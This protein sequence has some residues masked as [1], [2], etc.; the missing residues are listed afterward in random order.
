MLDWLTIKEVHEKTKIAEGTIRRYLNLHHR[1]IKNTK[2]TRNTI[3][4][5]PAS[6]PT[7]LKIR[8]WYGEGLAREQVEEELAATEPMSIVVS[9][10]EKSY[11]LGE[12]IGG[13]NKVLVEIAKRLDE[14]TQQNA[15]L[16]DEVDTLKQELRKRDERFSVQLS[17]VE[18]YAK[19][20]N[21][22]WI[23]RIFSQKKNTEEK[24]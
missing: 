22:S 6:V 18:K 17:R 3:K 4:I 23:R 15:M 21:D 10:G 8:N 7:I 11:T 12:Y 5:S 20:K 13:V 24:E 19:R 1:F 14:Q 16:V 9:D 2:D